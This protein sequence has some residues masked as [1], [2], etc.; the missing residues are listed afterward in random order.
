M[1]QA[2]PRNGDSSAVPGR[3]D[4]SFDPLPRV[5]R[6]RRDLPEVP[7]DPGL[8]FIIPQGAAHTVTTHRGA[9]HTH[10][11]RFAGRTSAA[12]FQDVEA[13]ITSGQVHRQ[14]RSTAR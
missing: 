4:G 13:C 2:S 1:D 9:A 7:A 14:G 5:C 11:L 3:C 10:V 12:D 8:V 6:R